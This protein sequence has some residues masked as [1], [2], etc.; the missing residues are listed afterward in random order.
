MS[1]SLYFI[2]QTLI[3]RLNCV[4]SPPNLYVEA[5]TPNMIFKDGVFARLLSLDEVIRMGPHDGI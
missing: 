5:L 1:I 3:I 4:L 2:Y